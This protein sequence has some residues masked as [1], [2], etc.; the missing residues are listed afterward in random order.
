MFRIGGVLT[1]NRDSFFTWYGR[2]VSHLEITGNG[3][4]N[5]DGS[6]IRIRGLR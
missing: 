4:E 3:R 5:S 1:S 6:I 2:Y